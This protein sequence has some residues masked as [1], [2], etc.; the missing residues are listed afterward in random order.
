MQQKKAKQKR[1]RRAWA[2]PYSRKNT[3]PMKNF[4]VVTQTKDEKGE[5]YRSIT[6]MS[7][8]GRSKAAK[9]YIAPFLLSRFR[10]NPNSSEAIYV[11]TAG[12]HSDL[13]PGS[14][15]L[16]L[17]RLN[18][19][20]SGAG[21]IQGE[22]EYVVHICVDRDTC[23]RR[24]CI[25]RDNCFFIEARMTSKGMVILISIDYDDRKAAMMA[26]RGEDERT[27]PHKIVWKEIHY[28]SDS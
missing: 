22:T 6:D 15:E 26:N 10:F 12:L 18:Q 23:H 9:N 3:G 20:R 27:S 7:I 28:P 21:T 11:R 19:S 1:I 16:V 24:L 14:K 2:K 4:V 17:A 13:S 8:K 5:P 25:S